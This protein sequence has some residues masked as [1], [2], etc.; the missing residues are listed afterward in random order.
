M[1]K[2]QNIKSQQI[3]KNPKIYKKNLKKSKKNTNIPYH[4]KNV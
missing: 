3:P 4:F 1:K 2:S